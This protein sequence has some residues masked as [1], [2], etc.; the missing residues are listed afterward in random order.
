MAVSLHDNES[1]ANKLLQIGSHSIESSLQT[2]I[3]PKNI[4][5]ITSKSN[6][7]PFKNINGDEI[8]LCTSSYDTE[9]EG[10]GGYNQQMRRTHRHSL[11]EPKG[12]LQRNTNVDY[13]KTFMDMS[14][15]FLIGP[16]QIESYMKI[17][18]DNIRVVVNVHQ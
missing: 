2:K 5:R 14:K 16:K 6:A 17:P 7:T 18:T 4:M 12:S 3:T 13:Q 9:S 10:R 1:S 8:N 11:K 15:Q